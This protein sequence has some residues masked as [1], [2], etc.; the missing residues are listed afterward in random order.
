M[1]HRDIC[2][3]FDN[4]GRDPRYLLRES[5]LQIARDLWRSGSPKYVKQTYLGTWDR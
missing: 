5:N 1:E 4:W 3:T 2:R